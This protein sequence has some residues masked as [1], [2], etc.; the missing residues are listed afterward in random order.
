MEGEE[1]DNEES[2]KEATYV[3]KDSGGHKKSGKKGRKSKGKCKHWHYLSIKFRRGD[4]FLFSK[5]WQAKVIR[6][7]HNYKYGLEVFVGHSNKRQIIIFR[8]DLRNSISI[9]RYDM[10]KS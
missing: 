4:A 9:L 7:V 1:E 10:S 5:I 3:K 2:M 8:E 6:F